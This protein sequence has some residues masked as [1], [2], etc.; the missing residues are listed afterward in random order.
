MSIGLYG[1][2]KAAKGGAI[3]LC[4]HDDYGCLLHIRASKIGD[5]GI[6]PDVFYILHGGEFIKVDEQS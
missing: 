6:E 4:E 2:A 5:N 1:R 3:V